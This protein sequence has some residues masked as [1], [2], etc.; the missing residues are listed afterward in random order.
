MDIGHTQ[1]R[2]IGLFFFFFFFFFFLAVSSLHHS[3]VCV[4]VDSGPVDNCFWPVLSPS[5]RP[6]R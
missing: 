4:C 2:R 1:H 5:L 3:F 6:D